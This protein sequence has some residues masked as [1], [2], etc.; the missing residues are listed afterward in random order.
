[1]NGI[2][3]VRSRLLAGAVLEDRR[4][5]QQ[6]SVDLLHGPFSLRCDGDAACAAGA[7]NRL[8]PPPA[9]GFTAGCASG[10]AST[11]MGRMPLDDGPVHGG[12]TEE[13]APREGGEPLQARAARGVRQAAHLSGVLDRGLLR[14][15]SAWRSRWR[16]P[17][18]CCTRCP[19]TPP[20]RAS[21]SSWRAPLL[22][23]PGLSANTTL[24]SW[25]FPDVDGL[26][27]GVHIS[28]EDV[29]VLELRG[30]PRDMPAFVDP[31][32]A[33]L[34]AQLPWIVTWLVGEVLLG[35]L[36]GLR[37]RLRRSTCRSGTC[38]AGPGGIGSSGC[39]A[40]AARC[41]SGRRSPSSPDTA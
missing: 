28:P 40:L 13:A 25:E 33:D 32:Q 1:M 19:T 11:K 41:G 23:R 9:P 7:V 14:W 30:R 6:P 26:P 5:V 34:S 29:D 39:C 36:L 21:P 12:A 16:A 20:C 8:T 27:I 35:L 18:P 37:A 22:T 38:A 31:L 15:R 17:R 4:P 10:D 3:A 24:G 2:V